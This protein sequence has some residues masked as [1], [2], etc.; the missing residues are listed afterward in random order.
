MKKKLNSTGFTIVELMIATTV[1]ATILMVCMTGLILLGK[2]YYKGIAMSRTQNTARSVIDTI[3]Q[4]IQF[5][6]TDPIPLVSGGTP[7][8]GTVVSST[9]DTGAFCIGKKRFSFTKKQNVTS[10]T[11]GQS[12]LLLDEVGAGGVAGCTPSSSGK[13]LLGER[14]RLQELQILKNGNNYDIHLVIMYGDPGLAVP[15][16]DLCATGSGSQFC[17]SAQLD[18]SAKRRL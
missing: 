9:V 10:G 16:G 8:T 2:N 3:S 11:P 5:T 13:E 17:A 12:A 6:S 1:F 15:A 4:S 18:T 7:T 14:M